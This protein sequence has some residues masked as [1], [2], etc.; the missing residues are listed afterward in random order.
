MT[1][2]SNGCI[3]ND[4]PTRCSKWERGYI[5][6]E[7]KCFADTSLKRSEFFIQKIKVFKVLYLNINKLKDIKGEYLND[8]DCI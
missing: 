8:Y 4:S 6:G 2:L 1:F 5:V 7:M 3:R